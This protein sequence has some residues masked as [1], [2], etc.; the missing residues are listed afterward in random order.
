MSRKYKIL[1]I[2]SPVIIL[3]DQITKQMILDRFF[4]HESVPV[5]EG[6]FSLT[7]IRNTGAAFGMLA[8]LDPAIRVP[9]FFVV[10]VIA[11]VVIA[12]L[13]RSLEPKNILFSSA[14]SLVC[15]GAIG[16]LVDRVRHGYVVDFLDFFWGKHHFPA[17]NVA[18][19][20]ICVGVFFLML[21]MFINGDHSSD[22]SS[23]RK[24]KK[25]R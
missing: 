18:D 17:F 4:L 16:N 21:D 15:G 5:I 14:L 20:A 24:K 12:Y 25:A 11:L 9:F 10:P 3:L 6:F 2:V 19:S 23:K 7:Y 22:Q 1:A 13:F 8:D